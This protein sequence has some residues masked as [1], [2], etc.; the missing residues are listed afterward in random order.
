M[1]TVH[2]GRKNRPYKS[3]NVPGLSVKFHCGKVGKTIYTIANRN[4]IVFALG[5][6]VT[7]WIQ[8]MVFFLHL[9]I[10]VE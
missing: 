3:G 2:I 5:L 7:L 9:S 10:R 1:Q 8:E 4:N 6:E